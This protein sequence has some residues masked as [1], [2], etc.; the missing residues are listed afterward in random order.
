VRT[1]Q[2]Q[3]AYYL[4]KYETKGSSRIEQYL[5]WGVIAREGT[6]K[7]L[8]S[9][10]YVT[11]GGEYQLALADLHHRLLSQIGR[12]GPCTWIL[13]VGLDLPGLGAVIDVMPRLSTIVTAA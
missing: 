12:L 4:F 2:T 11:H 8:S 13:W 9:L 6:R 5:N 7:H 10:S 3:Y 1:H